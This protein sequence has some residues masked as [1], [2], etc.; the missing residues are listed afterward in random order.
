MDEFWK[1]WAA[2]EASTQWYVYHRDRGEVPP[3]VE[4]VTILSDPPVMRVRFDDGSILD[5]VPSGIA[6]PPGNRIQ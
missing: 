1:A 5:V 6:R 2:R 3:P 4:Y